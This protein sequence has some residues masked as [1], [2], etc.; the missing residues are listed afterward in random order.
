MFVNYTEDGQ[1]ELVHFRD[2]SSLVTDGLEQ[3]PLSCVR[4]VLATRGQTNRHP[5][6]WAPEWV[7][8]SLVVYHPQQ[9]RQGSTEVAFSVIFKYKE[10]QSQVDGHIMDFF[11]IDNIPLHC[12]WEAHSSSSSTVRDRD[13]VGATGEGGVFLSQAENSLAAFIDDH[14]NKF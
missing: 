9:L 12:H 10:G 2:D 8:A 6:R 11:S 13:G 7:P 5:G 14:L 3:R 4:A 1:Y